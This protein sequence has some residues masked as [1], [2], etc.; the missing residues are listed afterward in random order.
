MKFKIRDIDYEIKPYV[1]SPNTEFPF[2]INITNLCNAKCDFCCNGF[3]KDYRKLD[4]VFLKEILDIVA[5]KVS[6]ISISGGETM[7]NSEELYNLLRLVNGYGRRITINTNG[8]FLL[9]NVDMLNQFRNV[10]SIQLSRHHYDD[11]K[12]NEIFKIETLLFDDIKRINLYSDLRI[13]CLLIDGYIDSLNEVKK[14]LDILAAETKIFQVGFISMMPVNEFTNDK[15]VDYR[16]IISDIGC[17]FEVVETMFDGDRCSCANYFYNSK[18][19]RKIFVYFKYTKYY[20]C[21]GRSLFFDCAGLK[22]GY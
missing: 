21:S 6:R 13:N 8:S 17:E 16:N 20:G 11:Q 2:Y 9:K 14:Y 7:I 1:C 3:N 5:S 10:E 15:F 18:C 19:G 12:N 22:E 4:L